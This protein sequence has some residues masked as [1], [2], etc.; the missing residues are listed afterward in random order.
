MAMVKEPADRVF[1]AREVRVRIRSCRA[2]RT[3]HPVALMLIAFASR[4]IPNSSGQRS[5]VPEWIGLR[6][7]VRMMPGQ[8]PPA[9]LALSRFK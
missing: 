6:S 9:T 7:W 4:A 2:D 5:F 8:G 3:S 1:R